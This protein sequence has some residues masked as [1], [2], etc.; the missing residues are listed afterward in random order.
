MPPSQA[1]PQPP[2]TQIS[3][4]EQQSSPHTNPGQPPVVELLVPPVPPLEVE[5]P[6]VPLEVEPPLD[7]LEVEEEVPERVPPLLLPVLVA[8]L[9]EWEEIPV[10]QPHA[11]MA[12]QAHLLKIR[13]RITR[14]IPGTHSIPAH[15][16]AGAGRALAGG[17]ATRNAWAVAIVVHGTAR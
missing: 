8:E 12:I 14:A 15:T 11:V 10:P 4:V 1:V 13:V 16:A 3:P 6:V 2:S 7:P 5:P 17:I 9:N